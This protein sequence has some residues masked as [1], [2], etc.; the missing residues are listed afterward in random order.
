MLSSASTAVRERMV[1]IGSMSA[2]PSARQQLARIG[3]APANGGGRRGERAREQR[4]CADTLATFEIAIARA[5]GI[6]AAA[7]QITVH[8]EA[9][10][11]ARFAPFGARVDEHS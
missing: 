10:R 8:A 4:A 6:L 9:H 1:R 5:D 11:A 3:H 2:L 7:D